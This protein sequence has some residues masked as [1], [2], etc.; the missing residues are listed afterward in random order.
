MAQA[1]T[2]IAKLSKRQPPLRALRTFC[3]AARRLSFKL[4][5]QELYV[6]ASAVSH[7]VKALEEDLGVNLFDRRNRTLKLTEAG[8]ALYSQIAPLI[9]ELDTVTSRFRNR[10]QRKTLR[11]SVQ[12]FFASELFVPKL[13]EFAAQHPDIDMQIDTSNEKLEAHPPSADVSIRLCDRAPQNLFSEAFYPLRLIPA[14]SPALYQE[15]VDQ[16]TNA[17]RS[18]PVIIHSQRSEQW[19]AWTDS[20]G[21]VVP[22]PERV[23]ELDTTAAVVRAAQQELGVAIVPMPLSQQ[24]FDSGLLVR[25]YEQ[26]APSK[27]RYYFVC[28]HELA[29]APQVQSLRKWVLKTFGPLS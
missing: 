28:S 3:A 11:I 23:I 26:E 17:I 21:I 20:T 9:G 6:T 15:I 5:A 7:Q 24:L 22:K 27:D 25:L 2:P 29:S 1:N 4:A 8:E 16:R 12:P 14:C 10:L 13:A 19:Q 18:F